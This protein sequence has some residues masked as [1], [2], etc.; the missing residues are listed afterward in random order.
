M[1][2]VL[3]AVV[4]ELWQPSSSSSRPVAGRRPV[5]AGGPA[6]PTRSK[7]R[8]QAGAEAGRHARGGP[9]AGSLRPVGDGSAERE[10]IEAEL[11]ERRAEIARTGG[12]AAGKGGCDRR[13][14]GGSRRAASS[15][16]RTGSATS[17]TKRRGSSRP[18]RSSARAGA[19]RRAQRRARPS[20]SCCASSRTRLRH[21]SAPAD[22]P[23]GGGGPPRRRPPR[24][25]HPRPR[26]MQ[27]IA[28]GHA[29]ETTVSVVELR[30]DELKGRI[31]GREG[32]NIRAL[33]TLTGIDFIIDD[34]PGGG[35]AVGL[36]RRAPRDRPADAREAAP[37]RAHPS[38]PDRGGLLPGASRRSTA[39]SW[40]WASRRCSRPASARCTPS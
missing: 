38:G 16:S 13:A 33:E 18:S 17:T 7:M 25:Q 40:R 1:E 4:G 10:G 24:A 31:I 3:A 12:A 23:G 20:R 15:R 26:C 19:G 32:R 11:R 2:I 39:T 5:A 28:G 6:S 30:S 35:A 36:R 34:T 14:A 21:D 37:G 9:G 29:V 22:P 8:R 27:R